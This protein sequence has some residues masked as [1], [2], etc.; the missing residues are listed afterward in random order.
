MSESF[1]DKL[2]KISENPF[3]NVASEGIYGDTNKFIDSGS[4]AFNVLLSGSLFGGIPQNKITALVGQ[5]G[6]G[7][8]FLV[9]TACRSFLEQSKDGVVYYFET[10]NALTNKL[11]VS[12]GIDT[13]RFIIQQVSTVEEL[14]SEI[15]KVLDCYDNFDEEEEGKKKQKRPPLMLC[16]DSLG[17]LSTSK[18]T[19]DTMKGADKRDMTRAQKIKGVFRTLTLHLGKAN[20]PFLITN[21]TYSAIGSYIP[22]NEI[23]GGMGI[24]YAS[25]SII[26]L[27]KKY[28]KGST[29][30]ETIG[31]IFSAK[32][33]K[34][35]FTKENKKVSLL[36]KYGKPLDRYY[37]LVNIAEEVGLITKTSTRY[38]FPSGEKVFEKHINENPEKYFTSEFLKTLEPLVQKIFGNNL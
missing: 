36:L 2:L 28:L 6:T 32:T 20:V 33:Y 29:A 8:T 34:S 12:R 16:L 13:K 35:R 30:K 23:S 10:E 21:H 17:M 1:I 14:G 38:E 11:L 18:E 25:S 9:L 24:K 22:R 5:E 15:L 4:Y 37:G 3:V 27:T 7:K 26:E 19:E 31:I